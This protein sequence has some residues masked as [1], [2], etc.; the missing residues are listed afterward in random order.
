MT[1][2]G[3]I[4]RAV[5]A[6]LLIAAALISWE[7][8]RSH[9]RAMSLLTRFVDANAD[10][11]VARWGRHAVAQ[12]DVTV[13]TAPGAVAARLYMPLGIDRPPGIVIVHGVHRLGI[14]EPRLQNFARTIAATGVAVLTPEVRELAD[15]HIDPASVVTIGQSARWM[16]QRIGRE[17]V[18]LM[19]LS[20]AGGLSIVAASDDRYASDIGF[21]VSV[22]G[23]HDLGRVL[24]FFLTGRAE[25]PDGAVERIAPHDYGPLVLV[26]SHVE[27]FFPSQDA[28]AVREAL[29]H[30]LWEEFDTAR[31]RAKAVPEPSRGKLLML[32]NHK[33]ETIRD[34][35]AAE[36][37]RQEG[38]FATVSPSA[39][40]SHVNVPLMFL[41]GAGD[42]VIPATETLWLEHDAP[43]ELVE[44]S[45]VSRAVSHVE[46]GGEPT[47]AD[48]WELVHFMAKL[49]READRER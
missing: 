11:L 14:Q 15:Y 46:L 48:R 28:P 33:I 38:H 10:G 24:R 20:F 44:G 17:R 13:D 40:L 1:R 27:A 8:V 9:A 19:G 45:L 41:H 2:T 16:H 36:I 32:F 49:L 23:H 5:F 18:G 34:E 22:G 4:R 3:V 25:R 29:R 26:Y 39:H 21:V 30:W 7:P 37:D 42:S 47:L 31:D 35:L 12:S 43:R 6:L